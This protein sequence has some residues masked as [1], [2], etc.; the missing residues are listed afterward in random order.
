MNSAASTA[1][2][3]RIERLPG[4]NVRA[5]HVTKA[6][7][8]CVILIV[9]WLLQWFVFPGVPAGRY[10]PIILLALVPTGAIVL[11]PGDAPVWMV[12][13][14][15]AADIV[16]V[17]VGI[18]FGGGADNVS[19]PL[20]Y[21]LIIGLGGLVLSERAAFLAAGASTLLYGSLV[22]A[23]QHRLLAHH[24]PYAKSPED[25]AATVIAVSVCLFVAAWVVSYAA[26][27]IR[28]VYRRAD[29]LRGDAVSALSHD[30][31]NPLAII[32]GYAEMM[33]TATASERTDY[34]HGI[35]R[36]ARGALDLVRNVLD[37]AAIEGHPIMPHREPTCLNALV[38]QVLDAYRFSAEA[39]GVRLATIL[40]PQLPVLHVDTQLLAR[41]I[42]NL[43]SNAIKY[44]DRDGALE[45]TTAAAAKAVEVTVRDSGCGIPAADQ[46]HIFE[47]YSR[48]TAA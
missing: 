43:V 6:L 36:S 22:W 30:L 35:R 31:K 29:E 4:P 38:E 15:L 24:L 11:W 3:W 37:A 10:T 46:P 5:I 16:A 47:K 28:A 7:A 34:I 45:V 41:A 8:I 19:G 27:Q 25:A 33:G 18:H 1:K 48:A 13:F 2:R 44:T 12:T 14:S 17:S 39:K 23:E 42:G 40:A 21:A 26:R 9:M 20:L 32:D